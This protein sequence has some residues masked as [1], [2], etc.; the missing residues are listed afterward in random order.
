MVLPDYPYFCVVWDSFLK[1]REIRL[2]SGDQ[3]VA[4]EWSGN[5]IFFL[6]D[7]NGAPVGMRYHAAADNEDVWSVYWYETNLQGDIVAIYS[8]AG[9]KLATYTYDAWGKFTRTYSGGGASTGAQYD[10]LT[11]RG[12]Y[13]DTDPHM[14]DAYPKEILSHRL[15]MRGVRDGRGETMFRTLRLR[16]LVLRRFG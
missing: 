12:Y 10:P 9:T 7:E 14:G 11:Y 6:Y 5:V 4:E 2:T 16:R 15:A 3:L 1:S 13:Y 8:S